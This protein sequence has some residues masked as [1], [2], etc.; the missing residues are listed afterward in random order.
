MHY[1]LT[2]LNELTGALFISSRV[3]G[4][5]EEILVFFTMSDMGR[6]KCVCGDAN[7]VRTRQGDSIIPGLVLKFKSFKV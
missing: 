7:R 1:F 4:D 3:K 2:Q 6:I 5:D